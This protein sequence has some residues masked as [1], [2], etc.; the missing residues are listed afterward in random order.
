MPRRA[1]AADRSAKAGDGEENAEA[2]DDWKDV[3]V[4][5]R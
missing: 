1:R 3:T 2:E 5:T 4:S